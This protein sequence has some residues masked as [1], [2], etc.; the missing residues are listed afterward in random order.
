MYELAVAKLMTPFSNLRALVNLYDGWL[1]V[2]DEPIKVMIID[3]FAWLMDIKF[4][5]E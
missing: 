5:G 2:E 1:N 3:I 4:N